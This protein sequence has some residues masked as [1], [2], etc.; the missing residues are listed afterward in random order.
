M[1]K[2]TTL[3]LCTL[4]SF[5][6]ACGDSEETNHNANNTNNTDK[7]PVP[8]TYTFVNGDGESTVSYSGQ[9]ARHV[10]IEDL[11]AYVGALTERVLDGSFEP[12]AA[13]Q[14]TDELN[15]Y[16]RFDG[17]A[18]GDTPHRF[19][20]SLPALQSTYNDISTNKQLLDK[21][22][23]NDSSTD[24][25]NWSGGDFKGWAGAA[26]PQA[27]VESWFKTIEDNTL[28]LVA[29]TE[30]EVNG[31]KLPVYVTEQGL[32]LNQLIQKFLVGA[33]AFSQAADDYGDDD[34]EGKGL[35]APNTIDGDA[36]YTALAHA[37]DEAFGYFGASRDYGTLTD[38]E[39]SNGCG[40]DASNDGK[41]DLNVEVCFGASV[42]AA[43]RDSGSVEAARTDFT[44][45]AF[46]GFVKGRTLIANAG[47]S[48]TAAE[49]T[50]LK[51]YR[52][53][54][55]GA[56]EKAY[57]ATVVHYINDVLSDMNKFGS[58]DYKFTDHAKH[59]G[60][61]KGFALSFQFNP[62]SP[63][64][65]DFERFHTLIGDAPV[66]SDAQEAE[67]TAYKDKLI[68]AR[69]LLKTAYAFDDANVQAW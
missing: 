2:L 62:R 14:V 30:R 35:L 8:T 58:A 3:L 28:A 6:I 12:T 64:K 22:A 69:D 47:E 29:G 24:H 52:D 10:L 38:A 60:E 50:E 27:L 56:W 33:I 43:K 11:K 1:K 18:N 53:Q 65:S 26:S 25:K 36:K 51:G 4:L 55:E 20:T 61:L 46:D 19:S 16:L 15:D 21:L 37:W 39:I 44:K 68:Q 42:N 59:W 45:E 9:I 54:W 67:I 48:L 63:M 41:L 7:L 40:K 34:I 49:L 57:A 32:D 66:L 31:E 17:E 23:G 13:G 5:A